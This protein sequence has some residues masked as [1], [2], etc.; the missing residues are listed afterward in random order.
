MKLRIK[1]TKRIV[2]VREECCY[3][4]D[5]KGWIMFCEGKFSYAWGKPV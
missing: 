4:P 2:E 5:E 1:Y 3:P